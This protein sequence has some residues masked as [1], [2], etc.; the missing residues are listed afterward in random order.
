MQKDYEYK[1]AWAAAN[2]EKVRK[3]RREWARR[4]STTY[5]KPKP[6]KEEQYKKYWMVRIKARAQK[7]GIP[8][9]LTLEDFEIPFECPALG[10]PLIISDPHKLQSPSMDRLDPTKG[11]IKGN[12]RVISYRANQV[13]SNSTVQEMEKVLNWYKQQ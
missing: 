11:Y 13:K 4:N 5:G 6:T 2:V 8:F 3:S 9:D 7:N 12:V 10:I 1:K